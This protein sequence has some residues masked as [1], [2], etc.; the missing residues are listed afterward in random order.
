MMQPGAYI[1]YGCDPSYFTRMVEAALR[2]MRVPHETRPKCPRVRDRL[3]ARAGTHLIPVVETP[4]G[5]VVHD[6]TH[7]VQLLDARFPARHV[8]PRT[9]RQKIACRLIDDLIDEWF[10]RAALHLR[11]I[12]DEEAKACALKIAEDLA[13]GE[14][15]EPAAEF[16][17][18]WGRKA[19]RVMDAGPEHQDGLRAEFARFLTLCAGALEPSGGFF[20]PRLSMA[21]LTLLGAM[22]AHFAADDYARAFVAGHA[23][24][25]LDWTDAAWNRT[26]DG[27]AF[28]PDDRLPEQ[29]DALL[30]LFAGGYGRF[31]PAHRAALD[32]GRKFAVFETADGQTL[33]VRARPS[34]E[35]ARQA[36]A[37]EI[38]DLPGPERADV[39]G[40]LDEA[41]LLTLFED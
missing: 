23:P 8:I 38:A 16:I 36:L 19:M 29:M 30:A 22:K 14:P 12:D 17:Q 10:V 26:L 11:W 35:A 2:Y 33:S 27:E 34:A 41:G 6:S 32:S 39:R 1:V 3:E 21:D 4:E 13:R 40:W 25:L 5:W 20:G 37:A 28:D 7:I 24:A 15:R 9:P 18:T 31:L